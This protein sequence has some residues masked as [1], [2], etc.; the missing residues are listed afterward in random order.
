MA[1]NA[2]HPTAE[3]RRA[4]WLEYALI[5]SSR[6]TLAVRILPSGQVEVR[7]PRRCPLRDIERFLLDKQDWIRQK[8]ETVLL[9]LQEAE[10]SRP[11]PGGTLPLHGKEYPIVTGSCFGFDGEHFTLPPGGWPDARPML[12]AWYREQAGK[13]LRERLAGYADKIG[14]FP[15]SVRVSAAVRRWGSCSGRGRLNFS[16]MLAAAPPEAADYVLVHELCHLKEHNHSPAF[17]RLVEDAL[18]DY[19]QRLALLRQTERRLAGLLEAPVM[20]Q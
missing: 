10:A 17:W 4:S 12:I 7:A 3:I 20:R 15:V 14:V 11:A 13:I 2:T 16:W 19:R 5:R 18:P 9:R 6:R 1:S 8:Q